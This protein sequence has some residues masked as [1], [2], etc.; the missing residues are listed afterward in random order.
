MRTTTRTQKLNSERS[1]EVAFRMRAKICLR[2]GKYPAKGDFRNCEVCMQED[3]WRR[4]NERYEEFVRTTPPPVSHA[5][6]AA[7]KS[8]RRP[9]VWIGKPD[10]RIERMIA[11]AAK[12]ELRERL[13]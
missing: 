13:A 8:A 10:P 6:S 5:T 2:C 7:W 12:A 11:L 3:S 1:R 9:P 4:T